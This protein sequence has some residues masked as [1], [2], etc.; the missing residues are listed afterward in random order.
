MKVCTFNGSYLGIILRGIEVITLCYLIYVIYKTINHKLN[1]LRKEYLDIILLYLSI[2]LSVFFLLEILFKSSFTLDFFIKFLKLQF[3]FLIGGCIVFEYLIYKTNTAIKYLKYYIIIITLV[4][5]S[6]IIWYINNLTDSYSDFCINN[7]FLTQDMIETIFIVSILFY[8]IYYNIKSSD[9]K[10]L[11]VDQYFSMERHVLK[12]YKVI[13]KLQ[14][15]YVFIVFVILLSNIAELVAYYYSETP[16]TSPIILKNQN[17]L[18]NLNI[19]ESF[20]MKY[21]NYSDTNK[22]DYIFNNDSNLNSYSNSNST[23]IKGNFYYNDSCLIIQG[24]NISN[25]IVCFLVFF[26]KDLI[27]M[28][29]VIVVIY[30][31]PNKSETN[32][33]FINI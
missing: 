2:V 8:V 24:T 13:H 6:F 30:M 5:I 25:M 7:L 27:V 11:I 17:F 32:Q 19:N 28:V 21:S 26:F 14:M 22:Q 1:L 10:Q 33:A 20:V 18:R 29:S 4:D 15:Y 23:I 3:S 31:R 9:D 16:S 12:Q